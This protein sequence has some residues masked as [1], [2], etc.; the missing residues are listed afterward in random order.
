MRTN[1]GS[2]PNLVRFN[3]GLTQQQID[4]LAQEVRPYRLPRELGALYRSRDG[5]PWGERFFWRCRMLP[6]AEAISQ[7]KLLR[8]LGAEMDMGCPLWFPIV[9]EGQDYFLSVLDEVEQETSP[10]LHFF[11]QDTTVAVWTPTI[12][13]AVKLAE[14]G[15]S[16]DIRGGQTFSAAADESWPESWR[17]AVGMTPQSLALRGA[18]TT[19]AELRAGRSNGTVVAKV[20]S[21][22][23]TGGGCVIEVRDESGTAVVASP[24]ETA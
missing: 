7:W 22:A 18:D 24:T 3:P 23:V 17:L 16:E 1:R 21:L 2:S 12:A 19:L 9:N 4:R 6:L 5:Q 20:I 10:V 8:Q 13:A 15:A 11:M 14:D